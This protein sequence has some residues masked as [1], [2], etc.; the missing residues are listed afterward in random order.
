MLG[1]LPSRR[2]MLVNPNRKVDIQV[3]DVSK[4]SKPLLSEW[5]QIH[6][7]MI[8][9]TIT[10]ATAQNQTQTSTT[11]DNAE[12]EGTNVTQAGGNGWK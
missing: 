11:D 7:T 5:T 6:L 1:C 10:P 12:W 9:L 3:L 4:H 8:T 2:L